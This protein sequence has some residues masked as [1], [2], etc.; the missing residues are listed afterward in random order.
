MAGV[1]TSVSREVPDLLDTNI[2][3]H[4]VRGDSTWERIKALRNPLLTDPRPIFS[5]VT[6]GEVLSLAAQWNWG[7]EKRDKL[8]YFLSYFK[9]VDIG[10]L[11][12]LNAYAEID[13]YMRRLPGSVKMGKNDLWIAATTYVTGATLVTT[14]KD[15]DPLH[16]VFLSRVLIEA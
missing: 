4:A 15:F 3:V 6:H 7:V 2:F 5:F 8:S 9:S 14:D 11:E 16:G 10:S 1:A 12:I 13:A